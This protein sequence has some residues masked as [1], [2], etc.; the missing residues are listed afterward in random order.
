MRPFLSHGPSWEGSLKGRSLSPQ[1]SACR[2][3]DATVTAAGPTPMTAET[4]RGRYPVDNSEV[5]G[6]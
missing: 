3:A 2:G 5:P 6:P 4:L 1:L